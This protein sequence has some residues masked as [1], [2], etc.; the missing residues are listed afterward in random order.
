MDRVGW[1]V[2]ALVTARVLEALQQV[3]ELHDLPAQDPRTKVSS[4]AVRLGVFMLLQKDGLMTPELYA[5][6]SWNILKE[7]G[8][9]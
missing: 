5:D 4:D 6:P 3:M 8:L 1:P 9:V 2:R 7:K